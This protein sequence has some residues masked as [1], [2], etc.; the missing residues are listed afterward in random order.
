MREEEKKR[1]EKIASTPC[2]DSFLADSTYT[3][4]RSFAGRVQHIAKLIETLQPWKFSS[5]CYLGSAVECSVKCQTHN[6]KEEKE[7][8][9]GAAAVR[10]RRFHSRRYR[11]RRDHFPGGGTCARP[12]NK[13]GV[14]KTNKGGGGGGESQE[15]RR[16]H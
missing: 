1:G 5:T 6:V 16:R 15:R 10:S 12:V 4:Y 13:A 14:V 3:A 7:G 11:S 2:R 9:K 8:W